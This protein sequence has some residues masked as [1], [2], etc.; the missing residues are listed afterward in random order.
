MRG[1][2]CWQRSDGTVSHHDP[3]CR[4]QEPAP[5]I[6]EGHA[7]QEGGQWTWREGWVDRGDTVPV[8]VRY[9][10]ETYPNQRRMTMFSTL[11]AF[12]AALYKIVVF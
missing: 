9:R 10:A 3:T 5:L 6:I 7:W 1:S 8:D 2:F 4:C 11:L 12:F